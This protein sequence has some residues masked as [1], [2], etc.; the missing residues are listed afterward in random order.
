M[1]GE[2]LASIGQIAV[3][4][5]DLERAIAFYRDQL[6]LPF[7]FTT[8]NLAF[9]M[10]GSVRLMLDQIEPSHASVLYY[11]VRNIQAAVTQLTDRGVVFESAP[12]M[13]AR[14]PDHE[15][16][17]AFFRDSENNLMALMSEVR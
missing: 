4:V 8:G 10:C 5:S 17:M 14:M 2:L 3:N 6:G 7:L 11:K 13:I 1:N 15:L 12:H 16:W 9:F